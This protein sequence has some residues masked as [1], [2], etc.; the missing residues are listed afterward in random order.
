MIWVARIVVFILALPLARCM[1]GAATVP[2]DEGDN[3]IFWEGLPLVIAAVIVIWPS[4]MFLRRWLPAGPRGKI[5]QSGLFA[6]LLGLSA[7]LI[8]RINNDPEGF[9]VRPEDHFP[10][11]FGWN[12]LLWGVCFAIAWHALFALGSAQGAA[13]GVVGGLAALMVLL[14]VWVI[15]P[16]SALTWQLFIANIGVA[17]ALVWSGFR[18]R[19]AERPHPLLFGGLTAMT[20]SLLALVRQ[21]AFRDLYGAYGS[22]PETAAVM[23]GVAL[24]AMIFWVIY[25]AL[26]PLGLRLAERRRSARR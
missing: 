4:S 3:N 20:L 26:E 17:A 9:L 23:T 6:G 15:S 7:Y 10:E 24:C 22:W 12:C 21:R 8:F 11:I 16:D 19:G 1:N 2:M 5:Y 25:L 18:L 14:G 13:R